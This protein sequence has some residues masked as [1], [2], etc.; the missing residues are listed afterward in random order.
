MVRDELHT[1]RGRG[2][3]IN[4][5]AGVSML[6]AGGEWHTHDAY[7]QPIRRSRRHR[8]C[9]CVVPCQAR[10][11]C[12]TCGRSKPWCVGGEGE[13]CDDCWAKRQAALEATKVVL[14]GGVR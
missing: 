3:R 10:F 2:R 11:T 9:S 6:L 14:R 8:L 4:R 1:G 7:D 13:S 12:G 5:R